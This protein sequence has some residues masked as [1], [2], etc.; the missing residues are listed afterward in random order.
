MDKPDLY[1]L[2]KQLNAIG[3][4]AQTGQPGFCLLMAL[5]QK[6][7]ELNWV[8]QFTM[9]N[10]ELL[11]KAGFNN[12]QSLTNARNKLKQL[13]YID[14]IPPKNRRYCGTYILNFDLLSLKNINYSTTLNSNLNSSFNSGLNSPLDSTFNSTLDSALNINKPNQTKQKERKKGKESYQNSSYQKIIDSFTENEKVKEAIWGYIQMRIAKRAKPTDR[15]LELVLKNL[16]LMSGGDIQMQINILNQST[17]NNWTDIY[18]L[19]DKEAGKEYAAT[20]DKGKSFD[21]FD[22]RQY[23]ADDLK[24]K[25]LAK[26]RGDI[27]AGSYD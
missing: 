17:M 1:T 8:S 21:N 20:K 16:T 13:K 3:G 12:V 25:L 10:T 14:Y 5:W 4:I 11:Y 2:L 19:K 9:T 24:Q 27:N 18:P 7:N 6:A 22:K 15:A 26:S 23:D